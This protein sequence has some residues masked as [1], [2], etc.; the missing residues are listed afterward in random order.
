MA[1]K[2]TVT[3]RTKHVD[4]HYYF[5]REFVFD[6][7]VKIVFV[8]SDENKSDMFMKNASS[9]FYAKHLEKMNWSIG[10]KNVG[11]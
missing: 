2:A 7:F 8:Q 9:D 10:R 1:E 3:R 6:K 5:L 11:E 4:A